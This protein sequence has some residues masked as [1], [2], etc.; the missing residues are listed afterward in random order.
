MKRLIIAVLALAAILVTAVYC[1]DKFSTKGEEIISTLVIT[2]TV[3][4]D[5]YIDSEIATIFGKFSDS[6]TFDLEADKAG[7]YYG[8]DP[9]LKT[10]DIKK[11]EMQDFWREDESSPWQYFLAN[12]YPLL[13]NTVYYYKAWLLHDGEEQ[14][15]GILSFKTKP[16]EVTDVV[17]T[18]ATATIL[19]AAEN[20]TV[21]LS[22]EVYPAEATDHSVIWYSES[23]SVATVDDNGLVTG[24]SEGWTN[25][26]AYSV[27]NNSIYGRCKVTVVPGPPEDAVDMGLPSGKY[28]ANRDLGAS[29]EL[30]PGSYF[31]WA[32]NH[33]KNPPFNVANYPMGDAYDNFSKYNGH[34]NYTYIRAEDN[35][36]YA[37][38]GS[39]WRVPSNEEWN[40]LINNCSLS[41][42]TGG[43]TLTAINKGQDGVKH[44]L[45]F[46]FSGYYNDS[47]PNDSLYKKLRYELDGEEYSSEQCFYWGNEVLTYGS[48][49]LY[50][51]YG[52][53]RRFYYYSGTCYGKNV[54]LVRWFGARIRP[55]YRIGN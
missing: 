34:D 41:K 8:T 31:S 2:W 44:S 19:L 7:F 10:G 29:S 36:A 14:V 40:E 22:A 23:T 54:R 55:I 51:K 50:Y 4:D 24:H 16:K 53:C 25:I 30:A 37:I 43:F 45:Y 33:A 32:E 20:K 52:L 47:D 27:Q 48:S 18:P 13:P 3:P 12:I 5:G 11:V 35:A 6:F 46:P 38:L 21:Q 26:T 9:D 39:N 17:V 49:Q 42:S 15:G 28:W 1:K